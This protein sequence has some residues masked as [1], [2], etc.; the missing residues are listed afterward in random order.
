MKNWKSMK[1]IFTG[2]IAVLTLTTAALAAP[3]CGTPAEAAAEVTGRT[4]EEVV[5][6]RLSG[7]PYGL[8][9]AESGVLE[10]FQAAMLEIREAALA[11]GVE[12]GTLTQEEADA[13]LE[14]IRQRQAVCD[15]TGAGGCGLG[16]GLGCG[17]GRGAGAG[18][19]GMGCGLGRSGGYGRGL[20]DGSCLNP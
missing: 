2:G 7:K 6:E 14:A 19:R 8:I 20:R 5:E 13:F 11:A 12:S 10:A 1:R 4:L 16:A 9:A 3:A 15:G 17:L 18:G